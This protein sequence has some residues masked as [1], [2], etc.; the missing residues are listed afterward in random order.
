MKPELSA[1]VVDRV[2]YLKLSDGRREA[3]PL[4][5]TSE[6]EKTRQTFRRAESWLFSNGG[7]EGQKDAIYAALHEAGYWLRGPRAG[8]RPEANQRQREAINKIVL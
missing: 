3:F 2:L 7:T 1:K 5:E 6:R 4:G 8:S